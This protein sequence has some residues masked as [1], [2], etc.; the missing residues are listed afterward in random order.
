MSLV[1]FDARDAHVRMPHGS[2]IYARRLSEALRE[3]AA[4][5]YWFAERGGAGPELWFEQVRLP[6]ELRRR[7]AAL[8][9][10]PN[11]FLPLR[12]S[13]PGVVTVHDLAFHAYPEDFG[14]A[15]AGSTARSRR[16]RRGRPS[17]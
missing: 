12:R 1:A 15:P 2:G 3:R 11:C 8:V 16:A 9:H 10:A 13:C 5:D 4:F 6:R 17:A 7:G 14:A